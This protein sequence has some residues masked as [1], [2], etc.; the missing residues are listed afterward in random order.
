MAQD[1][2][3]E[4]IVV[5][6]T[7]IT[8][9]DFVSAS[10]IVTVPA[11]VFSQVG[12][13]TVETALN[14]M[15]QFVPGLTGTSNGIA[16]GQATVDLRGLG[17]RRTLVL[18]DGRRL[19]SSNGD[20]VPDLNVIPP[21]LVESVEIVTGGASATYGS[22]AI[23]GVVNVKLRRS[24]DGVQ[25]GGRWGQTS[26]GDGDE[27]DLSITAGAPFWDGRGS[28]MGFVGYSDRGQVNQGARQFSDVSSVLRRPRQRNTRTRQGL[29]SIR[30]PANRGGRSI[31]HWLE[32][33]SL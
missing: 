7:R 22:D 12:S 28:V 9:P 3:L 17:A 4:E 11:E 5:T 14:L 24:L 1:D 23:A 31:R 27:Y 25:F 10:P 29:P 21:A 13:S 30:L 8:R 33:H 32:R 26:H 2:S 18:V 15:P 6:G 19:I 20:G 16:E